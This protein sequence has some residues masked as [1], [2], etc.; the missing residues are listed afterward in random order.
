MEEVGE[1]K[2]KMRN[3]GKLFGGVKLIV[4]LCKQELYLFLW[5]EKQ[6]FSLTIK[7]NQ[8]M[9]KVTASDPIVEIAGSADTS[10]KINMWANIIKWIIVGSAALLLLS[11]FAFIGE[12]ATRGIGYLIIIMAVIQ[13]FLAFF[14]V[15]I[16][17]ALAIITEAA[18]IIVLEHQREGYG[19]AEEEE[20]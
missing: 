16:L 15:Y 3:T 20:E 12:R 13:G 14:Y 2:L 11:G 4:Y 19:K 10:G 18:S 17:R 9:E 5:P 1:G 6:T 8:I 7:N